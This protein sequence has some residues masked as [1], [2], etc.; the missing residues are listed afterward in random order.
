ME[1]KDYLMKNKRVLFDVMLTKGMLFQYLAEVDKQSEELFIRLVDE[2][3]KGTTL[4][5]ERE[6]LFIRK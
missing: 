3:A 2:M 1:N 4:K 5:R 6:I